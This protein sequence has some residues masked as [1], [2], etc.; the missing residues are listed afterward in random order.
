MNKISTQNPGVGDGN[1]VT[2]ETMEGGK[3]A[4]HVVSETAGIAWDQINAAYPDNITEIYTYRLT[5]DI[6]RIL[7]VT[8]TDSTKERISSVTRS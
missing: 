3:R 8:Y 6:K 2:G 5:G 1:Y 4:L 7:T